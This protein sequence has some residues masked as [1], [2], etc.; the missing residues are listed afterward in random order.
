MAAEG[1]VDRPRKGI[2]S[3]ILTQVLLYI[4]IGISLG[5][6]VGAVISYII[7]IIDPGPLAID[8]GII[9]GI[10]LTMVVTTLIIFTPLAYRIGG[11]K[12]GRKPLNDTDWRVCSSVCSSGWKGSWPR[13]GNGGGSMRGCHSE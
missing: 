10:V 13:R 1:P 7:N 5:I 9:G 4:L 11:R 2:I 3:V 12:L 6:V 8:Y